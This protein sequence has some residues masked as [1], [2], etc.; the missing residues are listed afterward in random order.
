MMATQSL[1]AQEE[2]SERMESF[3]SGFS[4]TDSLFRLRAKAWS[5]YREIGLPDRKTEV[6]R[7]IPMRKF[8]SREYVAASRSGLSKAEGVFPESEKSCLVF[9]NGF[10]APELS[11]MQ[12][13]GIVI[14]SLSEAINTYGAFLQNQ[15]EQ[16]YGKET[17]PFAALNGALHG[18]G[19]FIYVPPKT[20]VEKP[21]E[22]LH[23]VDAGES[24]ML[25]QPRVHLFAG[26]G[27][28][29][30]LV[31]TQHQVSGEEFGVNG[32]I[33]FSIE[34]NAKVRYTQSLVDQ[35]AGNWQF[36]AVRA[37]LKRD[38]R[39]ETYQIID[40]AETVRHDYKVYLN[41]ENGYASLNGLMMVDGE[42]QGHAN[43]L[44]EHVAPHCTSQQLF[45]HALIQKARTSFEGK[46]YVHQEAQKTEAYQLNNNLILSDEA[47]ADS[48]PNLEIFAD[49]VKASHG[50]T[51][52]Q[53]DPEQ[54]FY[55]NTRGF[56]D[57]DAKSL[58]IYGFCKEIIDMIHLPSLQKALADRARRY[59]KNE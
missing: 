39:F 56:S 50:S 16:F 10:F 12:L 59:L 43:V 53:L 52:G 24:Q 6:F 35:P 27:A 34:E 45:K 32:A 7:Y 21:I 17:D 51:V 38:S 42:R 41:G 44:I 28:E 33:Y 13:P 40:G 31:S 18:E 15:W 2:C 1:P 58:L 30:D 55:L 11:S 48:K 8:F 22:I 9:V 20:V 5:C 4:E 37:A 29:V 19:L 46:I 36:E 26:K 49:D 14:A 23:L 47:Q 57:H 3:W 25:I 54:L